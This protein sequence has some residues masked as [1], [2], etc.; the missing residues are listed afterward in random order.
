MINE[1]PNKDK[2]LPWRCPRCG[3]KEVR[4][5]TSSFSMEV[6]HDGQLHDV[7]LEAVDIPTCG[8]CGERVFSKAVDEAISNALRKKLRLL[9][10]DQIRRCIA[11]LG[12]SQKEVAARLGV[13]EATFSR[14]ATGSVIQSRAMD[15]LLRLYFAIPEVR[16]VLVGEDQ[17]PK[18]GTFVS[19]SF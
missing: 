13:A 11:A 6:R 1:N 17:D 19:S 12:V 3:K 2:P 8:S 14:W 5:H 7:Q 15:N 10:P 16:Q 18:L 4:P 9:T